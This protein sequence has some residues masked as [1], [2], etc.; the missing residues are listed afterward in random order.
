[1]FYGASTSNLRKREGIA[2][3]WERSNKQTGRNERK[4]KKR[5]VERIS[6]VSKRYGYVNAIEMI[7]G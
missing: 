5:E 2:I 1:M 3:Q 6:D 7:V 4:E